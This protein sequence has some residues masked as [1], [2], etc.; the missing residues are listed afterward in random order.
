MS[1]ISMTIR[2]D[3]DVIEYFREL[4]DEIGI[5]YQTLINHYLRD[6]MLSGREPDFKWKDGK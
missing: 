3:E 2:L 4:A 5:P 1:K 6:C